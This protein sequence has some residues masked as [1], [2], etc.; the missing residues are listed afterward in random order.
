[1]AFNDRE[2]GQYF[3]ILGGRF[4]I[5]VPEGTPGAKT[6]INKENK[7]VHEIFHDSFTG[8]LVGIKTQESSYGKNWIFSFQDGADIFNLQLSY[9]NSF[10][11]NI[12]KILP[13][14]D[15]TK[16]MKVQPAVKIVDGKNKSS[17]FISQDGVTIKHAYTKENPNGLPNMEQIIVKGVAVWDDTKRIEFLHAMAM[18]DIVPKLPNS[19]WQVSTDEEKKT[20]L[21]VGEEN[22]DDFTAQLNAAAQDDEAF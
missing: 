16:E 7:T 3:T 1:M 12:L 20:G 4:C 15:L 2:P 5:K 14:V 18:R 9:S 22:I 8:K 21:E 10:A 19:K 11:T 6:R 17:L 13:N